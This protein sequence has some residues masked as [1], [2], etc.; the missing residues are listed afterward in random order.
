MENLLLTLLT[1]LLAG[2][3]L[4]QAR[5]EKSFPASPLDLDTSA[6]L[7]GIFALVVIFHHLAQRTEA[8]WVFQNFRGVGYL[9]VAGFFFL[10]GYGIQKQVLAR[11]DYA[12]GFFRRRVLPI[13]LP[14]G[15]MSV[16]CWV[17]SALCK[18]RIWMPWD[19]LFALPYGDTVVPF[20]WYVFSILLFYPVLLLCLKHCRKPQQLPLYIA[21]YALVYILL[22]GLLGFSAFWYNTIPLLPL[23]MCFAAQ[24]ERI[25]AFVQKRYKLCAVPVWIAFLLLYPVTDRVMGAQYGSAL[26]V[27]LNWLTGSLFAAALV[28]L[29]MKVRIGN[30]ALRYLGKHSLA[31]YLCQGIFMELL[32]RSDVLHIYSDLLFCVLSLAGTLLTA[33]ALDHLFSLTLHHNPIKQRRN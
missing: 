12:K 14:F 22:C 27:A 23:G 20:S 11:A 26:C 15:L 3:C 2:L 32:L 24:E 5:I 1:A 17:L 18:G 10:S 25:L 31:L 30:P 33:H 8:G 21:G 4:Y 6:A 7:K 9:C 29:L 13:L 16:L 28:L 19:M